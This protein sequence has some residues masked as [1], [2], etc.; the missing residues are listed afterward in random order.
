MGNFSHLDSEWKEADADIHCDSLHVYSARC[1]RVKFHGVPHSKLTQILTQVLSVYS[2]GKTHEL[3]T[4][5]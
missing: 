3:G 2:S 4:S 1:V 5:C